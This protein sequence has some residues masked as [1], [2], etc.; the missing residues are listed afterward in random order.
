MTT[1]DRFTPPPEPPDADRPE[2]HVDRD[3]YELRRRLPPGRADAVILRRA[4]RDMAE[5]ESRE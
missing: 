4:R 2:D 1:G 3:G 5:G